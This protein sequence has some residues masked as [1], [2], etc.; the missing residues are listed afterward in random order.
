[1]ELPRVS[2][3]ESTFTINMQTTKA[4]SFQTKNLVHFMLGKAGSDG[5]PIVF[6][7]V[8][9]GYHLES[10]MLKLGEAPRRRP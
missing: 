3:I 5:F 10:T 9:S 4:S 8:S 1:M 2:S 6:G 7:P